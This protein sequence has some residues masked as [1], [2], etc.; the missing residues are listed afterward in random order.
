[1]QTYRATPCPCGFDGCV[2]WHVEPVAAT[3]CV[4]FT[5]FQAVAVAKLLN[6]LEKENPPEGKVFGKRDAETNDHQENW[7]G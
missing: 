3:Q 1:M 2:S 5:K 6:E 7:R 4:S